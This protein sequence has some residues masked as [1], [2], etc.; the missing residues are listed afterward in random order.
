MEMAE[1]I[2][3]STTIVVDMLSIQFSNRTITFHT[4]PEHD[5]SISRQRFLRRQFSTVPTALFYNSLLSG[6]INDYNI[7]ETI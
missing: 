1:E 3:S 7:N 4:M 6:L 5:R 2:I